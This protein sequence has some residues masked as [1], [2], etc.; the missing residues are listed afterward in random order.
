MYKRQI[1][2]CQAPDRL[3]AFFIT[4]NASYSKATLHTSATPGRIGK[5]DVSHAADTAASTQISTKA[6]HEQDNLAGPLVGPLLAFYTDTP[7]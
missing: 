1:F 2:Q 5:M 4:K 7:A 6:K 3:D